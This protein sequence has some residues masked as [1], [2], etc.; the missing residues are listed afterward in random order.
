MSYKWNAKARRYIDAKGRALSDKQVRAWINETVATGKKRIEAITKQY[1]EGLL[2]RPAWVTKVEPE[3]IRMHIAVAE[4]ASGG[5]MQID[6]SLRGRIGSM[7]RFQRGKFKEFW[8]DTER[9]NLSADSILNRT[10]LYAD[11]LI[12]TYEQMRQGVMLDG[13]F[14]EARNILG[15]AEKHCSEC[16]S[17]TGWMSISDFPPIGT[18]ACGPRDHCSVEYR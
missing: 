1:T 5:R 14:K 17:I 4:I 16:P 9:L 18:R 2:T 6:A 13:G 8:L 10:S 7:V 3:I 11:S 12:G 15:A